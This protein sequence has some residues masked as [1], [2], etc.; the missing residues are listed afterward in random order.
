M[1]FDA[2]TMVEAGAKEISNTEMVDALKYAH[3][4][5]VTLCEAQKDYIAAYKKAF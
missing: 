1:L 2:I 3:G 5:I 4:L